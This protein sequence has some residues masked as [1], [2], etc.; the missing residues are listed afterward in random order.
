M[1]H[2]PTHGANL[3]Q[4][5]ASGKAVR[6]EPF[7]T[8]A[9]PAHPKAGHVRIRGQPGVQ[10]FPCCTLYNPFIV[11]FYTVVVSLMI[12]D[13][14]ARGVYTIC[15]IV[16]KGRGDISGLY[17]SIRLA[18]VRR[19]IQTRSHQSSSGRRS[20]HSCPLLRGISAGQPT[21]P[22]TS[23]SLYSHVHIGGWSRKR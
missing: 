16:Q 21:T 9:R 15:S 2:R 3:R 18:S 22:T 17:C 19:W 10:R 4:A 20:L 23:E 6:V 7:E 5:M 8:P 13:R 1:R 14:I 12:I 11:F